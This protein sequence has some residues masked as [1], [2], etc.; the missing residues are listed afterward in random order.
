MEGHQVK[1]MER[2]RNLQNHLEFH[3]LLF[4]A[5]QC[6]MSEN[7]EVLESCENGK[8]LAL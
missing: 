4:G 2:I 3:N 1:I 8:C 5:F 6:M 7:Q